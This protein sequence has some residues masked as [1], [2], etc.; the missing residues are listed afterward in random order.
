MFLFMCLMQRWLTRIPWLL[1][2]I[3]NQ[4]WIS[5]M[6]VCSFCEAMVDS[7]TASLTEESYVYSLILYEEVSAMQIGF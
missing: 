5:S 2:S 1:F 7:L 3:F 4:F 6:L